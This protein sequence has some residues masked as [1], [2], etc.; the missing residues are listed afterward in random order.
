MGFFPFIILFFF[1]TKA[2]TAPLP[3]DTITEL[4]LS[5]GKPEKDP[6]LINSEVKQKERESLDLKKRVAQLEEET[7]LLKNHLLSLQQEGSIEEKNTSPLPS[8]TDKKKQAV[9][10]ITNALG[11]LFNQASGGDKKGKEEGNI[12]SQVLNKATSSKDI[13]SLFGN[14]L[15]TKKTPELKKSEEYFDDEEE[16]NDDYNDEYYD[17][18]YY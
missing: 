17:E 7:S 4:L 9:E 2:N 11:N 12:M 6:L 14:I 3:V 1:Y 16:Y 13:G 5:I 18:D 15:K 10:G 8:P